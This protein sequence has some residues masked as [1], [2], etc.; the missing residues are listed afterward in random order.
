MTGF[1]VKGS[2]TAGV[3]QPVTGQAV[4]TQTTVADDLGANAAE[5]A[6]NGSDK[7]DLCHRANNAGGTTKKIGQRVE[8]HLLALRKREGGGI[9]KRRF[10]NQRGSGAALKIFTFLNGRPGSSGKGCE[11]FNNE[12]EHVGVVQT[13]INPDDRTKPEGFRTCATRIGGTVSMVHTGTDFI[14]ANTPV[15]WDCPDKET[16]AKQ[17]LIKGM[18]PDAVYPDIKAYSTENLTDLLADSI[19]AYTATPQ[20]TTPLSDGDKAV[21]NLG[22]NASDTAKLDIKRVLQGIFAKKMSVWRRVIGWTLNDCEPGHQMDLIL[23]R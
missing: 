12:Y 9:S 18:P 13:A 22:K 21:T 11:K 4:I 16:I 10:R 1:N 7:K 23:K 3:F 6:L 15:F 8:S 2:A 14:S 20:G 19:I 5:N 17:K